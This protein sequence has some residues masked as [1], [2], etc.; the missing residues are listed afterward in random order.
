MRVQH[1]RDSHAD[2][3]APPTPYVACPPPHVKAFPEYLRRAGYWCTNNEKTDYQ[4][5]DFNTTDPKSVWDEHSKQA[6]WRSRPDPDMPFFSVFN[7]TVTHESGMWPK[8]D[9]D[10][11]TWPVAPEDVIVPPYLVDD[12]AT[13]TAIA[14]QYRNLKLADE[15][16]GDRLR[17]LEE[18]GLTENTLVMLWS[19]H[20]E[21]L[22]RKKRWPLDSGTHVPLIA[23][24]PGKI[25]AGGRSEHVVT[26]LDLAATVLMAARVPIPTHL[27]SQPIFDIT[28]QDMPA[29]PAVF[30]HRDRHDESYDQIR[31]VRTDRY[32]YIRHAE[33]GTSRLI[34]SPYRNRHPAM[35]SLMQA[36]AKGELS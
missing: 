30:S 9:D 6:H 10:P 8:D 16:L 12:E 29:R 22:P 18:D 33:P 21:G 24:W 31:S 17:E 35:R 14:K 1:A 32:R 5:V 11:S 20:G 26:T 4:F 34:F 15:Q 2:G 3:A 27:Q 36:A 23:K 7:P 13:R 28:G 25:G 19:D